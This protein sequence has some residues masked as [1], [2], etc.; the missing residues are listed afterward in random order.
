MA[1]SKTS[2]AGMVPAFHGHGHNCGC[3]MH[4]HPM[5]ME[6]VSKEDFEGCEQCF[7]NTNG[8]ASGTRLATPF[9]WCQVIEEH[10]KFLDEQKH[11]ELGNFIFNNYWQA[12]GIISK[13]LAVLAV[14]CSQL[15]I[16]TMDLEH[17][18]EEEQEYHQ[19]QK[20]EP[21][22]AAQEIEYMDIL[23]RLAD[24]HTKKARAAE[25]SAKIDIYISQGFS[26]GN[27][28]AIK[29]NHTITVCKYVLL[30]DECRALEDE[31]DIAER[32]TPGT[33]D[34]E[35]A[36]KQLAVRQYQKAVD[37]L[38]HLVVQRLFEL[39]KLRMSGT[40]YKLREKIGKAL[41]A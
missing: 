5:Y 18:L 9:H 25:E 34:Y 8:L 27:I 1:H 23:K 31:L 12:L 3:Q 10:F 4:W 35:M 32:W 30:E 37:D 36:I 29:R 11:S 26:K 28:T 19:T 40:G 22:K 41:K 14:L 39:T 21:P 38:E 6:G 15:S 13:S 17:Y 16:A 2:L 7:S 20:P 33:A 24:A